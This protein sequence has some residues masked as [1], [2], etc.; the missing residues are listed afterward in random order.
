MKKGRYHHGDLR[1]GLIEAASRLVEE[2]GPERLTMSDASRAAGVS[3]AAPYRYFAERDEL[4]NAVA[5]E[6]M[7]RQ[8]EAMQAGGE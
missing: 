7:E 8:H 1:A 3:T 4:L 5:L 6:G 2:R